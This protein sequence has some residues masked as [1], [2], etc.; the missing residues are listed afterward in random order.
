[1]SIENGQWETNSQR[2]WHDNVTRLDRFV[3]EHDRL[4]RDSRH[5]TTPLDGGERYLLTWIRS[6]RRAFVA[7]R[8]IGNQVF[9]LLQVPG[10]SFAPLHE[11]WEIRL[12]EYKTFTQSNQRA[13][14]LRSEIAHERSLAR[15]AAKQRF[16]ARRLQLPTYRIA[17]LNALDFWAWG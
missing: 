17:R 11:Q 7:G 10:F 3:R 5:E 4:P 9:L 2:R 13:P 16:A 15:W 14:R 1:M 12:S 8:L 6:Q